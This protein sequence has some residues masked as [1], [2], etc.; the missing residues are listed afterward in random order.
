MSFLEMLKIAGM[1]V[2]LLLALAVLKML[3]QFEYELRK[4]KVEYGIS[5]EENF[6]TKTL[7]SLWSGDV[8]QFSLSDGVLKIDPGMDII[9]LDV[10]PKMPRD[11]TY[12]VTKVKWPDKAF[13]HA[14]INIVEV[15]GKVIPMLT[16]NTS[17]AEVSTITSERIVCNNCHHINIKTYLKD[18]INN[19]AFKKS[20]FQIDHLSVMSK[21]LQEKLF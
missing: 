12:I 17:S 4:E 18:T 14:S 3:S 10:F 6:E 5:W 2:V 11:T 20:D 13:Y 15:G 19:K 21:V 8:R 7:D 16:N 1:L 9:S